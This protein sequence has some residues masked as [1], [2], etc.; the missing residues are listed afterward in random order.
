[1]TLTQKRA[2][3][4]LGALAKNLGDQGNDTEAQRIVEKF[5]SWLGVHNE[6]MT[7]YIADECCQIMKTVY[8]IIHLS[9]R[10]HHFTISKRTNIEV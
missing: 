4:T 1:M 10:L 7:F 6:S 8:N 9:E 5:E 2:C 3:L